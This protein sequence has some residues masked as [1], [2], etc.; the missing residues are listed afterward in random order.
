M[1]DN[2]KHLNGY[3]VYPTELVFDDNELSIQR[4]LIS[5]YFNIAFAILMISSGIAS[6][7]DGIQNHSIN[8]AFYLQ[9]GLTSILVML[10]LLVL[11]LVFRFRK[12]NK[13]IY[14]YKDIKT[15][16]VKQVGTFI[17]LKIHFLDN[18]TDRIKLYKNKKSK[19]F[20]EFLNAIV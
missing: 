12:L 9:I 20:I 4:P 8:W 2:F 10:L 15:F 16:E 11:Y 13:K 3:G 14:S 1:K 5:L 19:E 6:I 17:N 7:V 18:S